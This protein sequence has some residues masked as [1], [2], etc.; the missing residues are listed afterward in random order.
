[1]RGQRVFKE[2]IKEPGLG[3]PIVKGRNNK[4]VHRR[5][6]C[7]LARYYY[8]G[9]FKSMC[10]EETIRQLVSEFFLSPATIAHIIQDNTEHIL[11]L[12]QRGMVVYYF[13]NHWPH[14]KW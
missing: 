1:M 2:I 3:S 13:Q 6:E 14:L 8:Y 5:N 10:Y 11:S 12:K 9:F 4:L 7:L